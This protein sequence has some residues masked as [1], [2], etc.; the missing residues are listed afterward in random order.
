M[1]EIENQSGSRA[2]SLG[3]NE[4]DNGGDDNGGN[5]GVTGDTVTVTRL[6]DVG[7]KLSYEIA[8]KT[9]SY[10]VDMWK[11]KRRNWWFDN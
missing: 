8:L 1:I 7:E 11:G 9:M 10:Y 3:Q 4:G 6:K 2:D 5:N